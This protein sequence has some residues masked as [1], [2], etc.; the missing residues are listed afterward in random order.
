MSLSSPSLKI[1]WMT[2]TVS[3][4]VYIHPYVVPYVANTGDSE[5]AEE[6]RMERKYPGLNRQ[7]GR[8]SDDVPPPL[9]P[10]PPDTLP[11]PL[12]DD[13]D[14][15]SSDDAYEKPPPPPPSTRPP[16]GYTHSMPHTKLFLI[17]CST[18]TSL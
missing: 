17:T 12:D 13:D 11:P 3:H 8:P 14:D 16:G 7:Y 18:H 2:V 1:V 9:P 4:S 6:D 15:D 5:E 10:R